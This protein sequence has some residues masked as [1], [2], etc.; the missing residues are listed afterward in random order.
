MFVYNASY[1]SLKELSL[2]Y[3][4]PSSFLGEDSYFRAASVGVFGKN[5]CYLYKGTDNIDPQA[6]YS[7]SNGASGL[8]VG[9]NAMPASFGVNLNIKF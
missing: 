4:L 8:E 3:T 2:S 5:L 6:A 9:N 1:V 7:I